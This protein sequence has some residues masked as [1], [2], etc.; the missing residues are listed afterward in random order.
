[1]I[2]LEI[3]KAHVAQKD[4]GWLL[5]HPEFELS[6]KQKITYDE[7]VKRHESGEPLPYILGFKEFYGRKFVVNE[8][9]L[10]PR[11]ESELMIDEAKQIAS[12]IDNP[13]IIDI[14]T[15]TGCL[16][17]TAALEIPHS[18]V[19]ATDISDEAL[20]VA[21]KN[22]KLLGAQVTFFQGNL[23]DASSRSR[24]GSML[25]DEW[26]PYDY[27]MTIIL[28][29][30]PYIPTDEWSTLDPRVKTHEPQTALEGGKDGLDYYRELLQQI[31]HK[32]IYLLCEIM[33]DQAEPLSQEIKKVHPNAHIEIK[34]DLAG[35]GRLVIA[36]LRE[37]Q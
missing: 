15:G 9:T 20:S 19:H 17:I 30:L 26:I 16:A 21:E 4:R 24:T 1:M 29:N 10:I 34:K 28:A 13:T 23:L 37:M 36:S 2:E 31:P 32:K 6:A 8:H 27:G 7:Y 3:I 33:P 35:L 14:G 11:P 22:S 25:L 18:K 5:A 12:S